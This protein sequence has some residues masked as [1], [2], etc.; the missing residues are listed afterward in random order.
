MRRF[1]FSNEISQIDYFKK[2]ILKFKNQSDTFILALKS[3]FEQNDINISNQTANSF[4]FSFWGLDLI[5]K[6]EISFDKDEQSFKQ[7]EL[8]TYLIKDKKHFLIMSYKFDSVGNIGD[9]CLE[10]DFA[11]FYYVDL[12]NSL[13]GYTKENNIKFQL[14]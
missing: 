5:T 13:I 1:N 9:G 4:E 10:N 14:K 2:L 8:N 6:T 7:G 3:K 12:V 11:D